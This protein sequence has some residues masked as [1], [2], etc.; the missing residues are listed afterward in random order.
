MDRTHTPICWADFEKV[1]LRGGTIIRAEPFPEAC[2]PTYKFWI[3]F[4]NPLDVKTASAQITD[5]CT[6][7][8]RVGKQV[9]CVTNFLPKQIGLLRTQCLVTGFFQPD[10]SVDLAGPDKKVTNGL[11]LA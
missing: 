8:D 11:K 5:L 9:I 2:K 6:L 1:D 7:E 3:D 10:G 4:G